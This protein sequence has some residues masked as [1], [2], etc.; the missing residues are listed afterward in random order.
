MIFQTLS[1]SRAGQ[2]TNASKGETAISAYKRSSPEKD[3]QGADNYEEVL[4]E[5]MLK[6]LAGYKTPKHYLVLDEIPLNST[7]KP[8]RLELQRLMNEDVGE[9]EPK[10]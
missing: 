2:T 4:D 10:V 7:A 8:D 6:N 9:L 5:F 1:K 3:A